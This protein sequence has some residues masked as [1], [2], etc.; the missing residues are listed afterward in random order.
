[1][2]QKELFCHTFSE[3]F[4]EY[5][6]VPVLYD[7]YACHEV[8]LIIFADSKNPPLTQSIVISKKKADIIKFIGNI[9]HKSPDGYINKYYWEQTCVLSDLTFRCVSDENLVNA[10]K[11]IYGCDYGYDYLYKDLLDGLHLYFRKNIDR[12][13]ASNDHYD[14]TDDEMKLL[15]L[16]MVDE[17]T[18]CD[19]I[20]FDTFQ[21]IFSSRDALYVHKIY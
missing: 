18:T 21:Y 13:I 8:L 2:T 14:S 9:Y 20:I 3:L 1:M 5:Y 12:L 4:N 16:S 17:C 6:L 11:K 7:F 19:E 10:F 15:E